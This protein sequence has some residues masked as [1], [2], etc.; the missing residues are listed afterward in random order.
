MLDQELV[1]EWIGYHVDKIIQRIH[2]LERIGQYKSNVKTETPWF[3]V[4]NRGVLYNKML[5]LGG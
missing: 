3:Q 5:E 1:G 4:V 2:D